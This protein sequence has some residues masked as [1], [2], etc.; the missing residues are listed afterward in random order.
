MKAINA[1][2]LIMAGL[3][4]AMILRPSCNKAVPPA[5][6]V[7]TVKAQVQKVEA[8]QKQSTKAIDSLQA[9]VAKSNKQTKNLKDLLNHQTERANVLEQLLNDTSLYIP[10]REQLVSDYI[11][12]EAAED[13]VA[14][15]LISTME[16]TDAL[17]DSIILTQ[18]KQ[19]RE[20]KLSFDS[21]I[22]AQQTLLQY[23]QE[24][25][26]ALR[27][28]KAGNTIWKAA[29]ITGGVVILLKSIR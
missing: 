25:K 14:I 16:R 11:K 7:P 9:L 6:V 10:A 17:K 4:I 29:A 23:Q 21:S 18:A 27:W 24:L 20:L 12:A 5:P 1:L 22:I 19:N 26:K 15:S 2:I 13:T 3:I 8:S 28:R